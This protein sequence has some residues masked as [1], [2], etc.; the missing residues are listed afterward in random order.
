MTVLED[1][2]VPSN[3]PNKSG[4]TFG[5]RGRCAIAVDFADEFREVDFPLE[6]AFFLWLFGFGTVV[7]CGTL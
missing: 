5:N 7:V 3:C 1:L 2:S 4:L 6:V